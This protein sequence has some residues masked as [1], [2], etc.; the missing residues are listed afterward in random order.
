VAWPIEWRVV[1]GRDAATLLIALFPSPKP[2]ILR[3]P[4][5][6]A[7]TVVQV[8]VA[9]TLACS[10]GETSGGVADAATHDRVAVDASAD[11]PRDATDE[12]SDP[13]LYCGPEVLGDA[14]C[15]GLT[16]LTTCPTGCEP[17]T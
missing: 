15:P 14:S 17:L 12:C 1:N 3:I 10:S 4:S 13:T 7:F 8:A 11:G 9:G 16:C 6:L 2:R 5:S